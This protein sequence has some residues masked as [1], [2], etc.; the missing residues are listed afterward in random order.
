MKHSLSVREPVPTLG[1]PPSRAR[2]LSQLW[3]TL[4]P[5]REACPNSGKLSLRG[6]EPVPTLGN[7]P[8]GARSLSQLRETLPER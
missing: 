3:E 8:S 1:N 7:S 6:A 5:G 2:S 4:P